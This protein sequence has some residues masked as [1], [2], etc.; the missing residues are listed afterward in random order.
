MLFFLKFIVFIHSIDKRSN[1]SK[2]KGIDWIKQTML[3]NQP[4]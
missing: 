4:S 2:V 3:T 1:V